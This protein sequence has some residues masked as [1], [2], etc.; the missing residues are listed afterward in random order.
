MKYAAAI[1]ALLIAKEVCDNNAPI[2]EAN[3]N[4]Y[5]AALERSNSIVYGAAIAYLKAA[6]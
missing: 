5:Q 4:K 1:S 2:N 3:G 6:G